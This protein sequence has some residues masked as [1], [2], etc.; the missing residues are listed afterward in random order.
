MK[1]KMGLDSLETLIIEKREAE[2]V[3]GESEGCSE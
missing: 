2:R 3:P 1:L